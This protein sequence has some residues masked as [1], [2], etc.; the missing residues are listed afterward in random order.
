MTSNRSDYL[1]PKYKKRNIFNMHEP[2]GQLLTLI[3]K[4]F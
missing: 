4:N 3:K 2:N 1:N